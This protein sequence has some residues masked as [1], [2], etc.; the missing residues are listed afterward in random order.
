M[1]R[2]ILPLIAA[3]LLLAGCLQ[4]PAAFDRAPRGVAPQPA[5]P[6][7]EAPGAR[8]SASAA[9]SACVA[10]G[11]QQGLNVQ[12]VV[13]TREVSGSDGQP[14]SRDVMLRVARGQQL[15]EL[16][17]SYHYASAQARIMTL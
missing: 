9:E 3:P 15:Y 13:G 4:T 14:A 7:P 16:R 2:L 10:A 8:P 6:A 11:Q 5:L 12:G 17:C 1:T